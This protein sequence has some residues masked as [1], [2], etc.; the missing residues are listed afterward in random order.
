MNSKWLESLKIAIINEDIKE[1]DK[2]CSNM[3]HFISMDETLEAKALIQESLKLVKSK[4]GETKRELELI[5]KHTLF[6]S[7]IEKEGNFSLHS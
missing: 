1:I 4:K 6:V 5:K 3:P 2:L 7:N